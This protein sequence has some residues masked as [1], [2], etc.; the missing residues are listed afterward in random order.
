MSSDV[1]TVND[2][3]AIERLRGRLAGADQA[4][5]VLAVV[6]VIVVASSLFVRGFASTGNFS[7][8]LRLTAALG[9]VAVGSAIVI[10]AKGVDL[11]AAAMVAVV[12]QGSVVF[13]AERGN[14]ES[15]AI[16]I[17]LVL[18][19]LMGLINGVL[20]AY[21]ELPALFVTL[22]TAQLFLGLAKIRL[23][24][25]ETYS[26]PSDSSIVSTLGRGS[27]IG[28]PVPIIVMIATFVL[29]HA[30]I[31]WTSYGRMIRALGDNPS[32]A[33][34]TGAPVRPLI[35]AT[36]VVAAAL[37][38]LGAILTLG[39]NG[40]YSTSYGAGNDLLFD[41][42]TVAVIGGVSLTGGR[43]SI[44][45][46]AAGTVLIAV[47]VNVMTLLDFSIVQRNLTK[48]LVL[49]AALALDAWLHPRDEETAKSDDL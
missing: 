31:N 17:V 34:M 2:V 39:R 43:G 26:L 12:A 27:I 37:A 42:I 24:D 21:V 23:L 36:F 16:V 6:A 9:V 46:V 15:A 41:A 38:F 3:S 11:S 48:G 10:L 29:A 45:G 19:L 5:V 1:L 47:I 32:T 40:G 4:G 49:I 44:T 8:L 18:A 33:R 7:S 35:V 13:W 22:G 14:G 20:V 25:N 30:F 28:I